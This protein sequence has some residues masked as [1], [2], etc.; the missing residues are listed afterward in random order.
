MTATNVPSAI[1]VGGGLSGIVLSRELALRGWRVERAIT[2][3]GIEYPA[4]RFVDPDALATTYL[5]Y[6]SSTGEILEADIVINA[7]H[8]SW[9]TEDCQE[10][11]DLQHILAHE[12]GH[13]LGLA[14]SGERE[15]TM[16]ASAGRCETQKRKLSADDELAAGDSA[17]L[18]HV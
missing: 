17:R 7:V 5:T 11:Y 14:H 15:S 9:S 6:R 8:Y 4:D 2:A 18:R 12:G 10:R 13:A 1:V 3:E 16:F